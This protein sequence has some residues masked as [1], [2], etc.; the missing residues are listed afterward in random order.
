MAP[1]NAANIP[2][3]VPFPQPASIQSPQQ[4]SPT[5]TAAQSSTTPQRRSRTSTNASIT[6]ATNRIRTASVKLMEADA[7]L[8]MWAATGQTASKAPSISEIRGGTF[9]TAGWDEESQRRNAGR[10]ASLASESGKNARKSSTTPVATTESA[11]QSPAGKQPTKTSSSGL[12]TAAVGTEP[13]PAVT[14]E[15]MSVIP[16]RESAATQIFTEEPKRDEI[17]RDYRPASYQKESSELME[18][19]RDGHDE[20]RRPLNE[21]QYSNGYIP[22][23]KVPWKTSTVIGL[24][25]F[26]KWFLTPAGFLITIYSLNIVAWGGMLFLLLCNAAPAMCTPTCDD[27]NSPRR[28]WVEIDSQILNSL[29]CVTGF[30]LA[31]WRTRDVYWWGMWRLGGSKRKLT[32]IR[33]LAGI[34]RGWFRLPGSDSLPALAKMTNVSPEDPSVPIPHSKIPD[35]PPTGIH[36][37]PTSG[38]KMDFVVWMNMWN[39]LFQIVLCFYMWHYNRYDRPSWATGLFVGLG[40]TVAAAGGIMMYHEGKYVKKVEGVPVPKG[41]ENRP[42]DDLEANSTQ[43]DTAQPV[44]AQDAKT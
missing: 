14:E 39:T 1:P 15:E 28:I 31:P 25:A 11:T 26:W 12:Q 34:H 41:Y 33:R 4:S 38:W 19:D 42:L 7:P 2:T 32:G 5:D 27:I 35:P 22:P 20:S 37:P 29:F 3:P 40:C 9:G 43:K 30:G 17:A 6:S 21:R 23:P 24:K 16:T 13:F 18:R 10:R 44:L 36:A 8:G